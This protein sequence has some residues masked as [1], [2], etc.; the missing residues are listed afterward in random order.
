MILRAVGIQKGKKYSKCVVIIAKLMHT[1]MHYPINPLMLTA[2]KSI[3]F[4]AI[5]FYLSLNDCSP[6]QYVY[7]ICAWRHPDQTSGL[8]PSVWPGCLQAHSKYTYC[9][10]EQLLRFLYCFPAY[11]VSCSLINSILWYI[12]F[13]PTISSGG[14]YKVTFNALRH[15][16]LWG[17][18][19]QSHGTNPDCWLDNLKQAL[20]RVNKDRSE[21]IEHA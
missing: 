16:A 13:R 11:D 12:V 2:A 20:I 6:G 21:K 18:N 4:H 8:R 17:L 9:P 5:E 3:I 14:H 19:D 1:W 10:G 7:L 15:R